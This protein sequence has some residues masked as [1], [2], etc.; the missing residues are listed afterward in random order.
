MFYETG[1]TNWDMPNTY[2]FDAGFITLRSE[3]VPATYCLEGSCH[4]QLSFEIK[5]NWEMCFLELL[6]WAEK[7]LS[8]EISKQRATVMEGAFGTHKD[9]YGL[10]KIKVKGEKR[11]KFVVLFGIMA[12]NAMLIAKRS[13]QQESPHALK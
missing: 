3:I 6:F 10:R 5:K 2:Y 8:S 4:I 7:I 11:E 1:S 13:S 12:A 9:Y